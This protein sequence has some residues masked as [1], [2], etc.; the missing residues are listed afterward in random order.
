MSL[1]ETLR[2]Y[3]LEILE[4]YEMVAQHMKADLGIELSP[5]KVGFI[6]SWIEHYNGDLSACHIFTPRKVKEKPEWKGDPGVADLIIHGSI[7]FEKK[8]KKK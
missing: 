4:D 6:M 1:K 3:V 5:E 8:E 7:V 2:P